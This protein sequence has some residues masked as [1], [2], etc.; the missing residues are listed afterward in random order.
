MAA[1]TKAELITLTQKEF[2]KLKALI[3]PITAET[4]E[5]PTA[6]DATIKDTILHRAHW[7]DLF[8]GWYRGGVAGED[9]AVPAD[10]YKWNQLKEYNAKVRVAEAATPWPE[11]CTRIDDR[12]AALLSLIEGLDEAELYGPSP[13]PWTGKWTV[14][15]YAEASGPS[16]Y[17]SAAKYIRGCLKAIN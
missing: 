13:Y 17:R 2:T 5:A 12:H 14:G 7:I 16:H 3:D 15:R 9:V 1:T 4:A 10:G 6:D 11:A 8:F